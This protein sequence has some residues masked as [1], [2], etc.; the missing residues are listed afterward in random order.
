MAF[1]DEVGDGSL[2]HALRMSLQMREL[3]AQGI[4]QLV[5]VLRRE[6]SQGSGRIEGLPDWRVPVDDVAWHIDVAWESHCV[7]VCF[8]E[9]MA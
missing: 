8:Q 9:Y 1:L 5:G 4:E 3:S 2:P 7:R 6:E